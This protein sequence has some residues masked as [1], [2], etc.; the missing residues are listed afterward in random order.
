MPQ[1]FD[2]FSVPEGSYLS[3]TNI[4]SD[5]PASAGIKQLASAI[6]EAP[7]VLLDMLHGVGAQRHAYFL[8][9]ATLR[10]EVSGLF[11]LETAPVPTACLF[12]GE[13]VE[14][15]GDVA[16][17]LVDLTLADPSDPVAVRF[18]RDFFRRHWPAG[19]SILISTDADLGA[20]RG[21]LRR[22]TRLPLS[23]DGSVKSFRFWDPRVLIPFL[24]MLANDPLRA[25]RLTMTDQ[26]VPIRYILR[27]AEG[28]SFSVEPRSVLATVPLRAMRLRYA[29]FATEAEARIAARQRRI[30]SRIRT[31]FKTEL[32]DRPANEIDKTVAAALSHYAR[33]GF[34]KHAHLHM[35]AAW[36]VFYGIG[37]EAGDPSGQLQ[38]IVASNDPEDV[39]FS[40]FRKVFETAAS[41]GERTV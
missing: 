2:Q 26:G 30:A 13:T 39:R 3:W 10:T 18:R 1:D 40:A 19:H 23:E 20:L 24:A 6:P 21:H 8:V 22:F 29:D 11:D 38:A 34:R 17:W 25:R 41:A 37:F 33:L 35:F 16:P 27:S 7:P 9:D 15:M 36:A 28:D 14:T 12:E 4:R 32:A 31:D 5:M